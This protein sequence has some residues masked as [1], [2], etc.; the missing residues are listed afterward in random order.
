M[1]RKAF[2]VAATTLFLAACGPAPSNKAPTQPTAPASAPAP[3]PAPAPA[4]APAPAP[5]AAPTPAPKPKEVHKTTHARERAPERSASRPRP[6]CGNCGR[7][8]SIQAVREE[9]KPG[10]IGTLGGAAAG[11]L[12]GNQFG[13]GTGNAAM[14]ALGAIG[15]A[16]AGREAQERLT[17]TTVYRVT[18][19]MDTG[20]TR[21]FTLRQTGGLAIGSRVH[22]D[23][24]TLT[25]G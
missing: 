13:K 2:I 1:F 8:A 5:A 12:I 9:G 20:G 21:V 6:V 23:G 22:V 3:A 10:L 7:V 19:T 17:S 16:F 4:T 18:V 14:T 11:G 15:G 24:N 25:P